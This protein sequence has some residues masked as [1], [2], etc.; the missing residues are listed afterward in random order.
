VLG[1]QLGEPALDA[2]PVVAVGVRVGGGLMLFEFGDEVVLPAFQ[3]GDLRAQLGGE[4]RQGCRAC[5][6]SSSG[7]LTASLVVIPACYHSH[8][9]VVPPRCT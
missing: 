2:L 6:A 5:S 8:T 9:W 7:R 4:Q 3:L 1:G